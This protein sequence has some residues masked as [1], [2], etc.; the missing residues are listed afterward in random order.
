MGERIAMRE[1]L[2]HMRWWYILAAIVFSLYYGIRGIIEESVNKGND[3][4]TKSKKIFVAYIQEFL[5]KV[6]FT[7]S[8][9]FALSLAYNIF[10]SLKSLNE[11]S[12][13]TVVLLVF[14]F[15]W[16]VTGVAGYLTFLI[17][18]GKFPGQK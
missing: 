10:V 11:I 6:I 15:I 5:F 18:S 13:G 8:G 3:K 16:G 2:L 17:V 4:Y 7:M 14:L 12:A 1:M 9:F